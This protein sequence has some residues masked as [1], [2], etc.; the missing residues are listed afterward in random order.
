MGYILTIG[1]AEVAFDEDQVSIAASVVMLDYAPAYGN[2]PEYLNQ[3]CASDITWANTMRAL[4]LSDVMFQGFDL[5]GVH[6]RAL[7]SDRPG[8][9]RIMDDHV[10]IVESKVTAYKILHPNYFGGYPSL[11]PHLQATAKSLSHSSDDYLA[12]PQYDGHLCRGE[13]LAFWLRW[14]FE[15]CDR[16]V[17][18]NS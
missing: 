17:F 8:I 11:I 14:A 9:C 5:G 12:N 1:Q 2:H 3:I 15:N 18:V 16:P 4:N 6:R 13:W 10:E 7:I